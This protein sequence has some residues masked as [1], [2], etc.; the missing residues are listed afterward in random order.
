MESSGKIYESVGANVFPRVFGRPDVHEGIS[1]E[2]ETAFKFYERFSCLSA[3]S[4]NLSKLT[5]HACVC[6]RVENSITA[7]T[8]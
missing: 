8:E 7:I 6:A 2:E 4:G 1:E 5:R 3:A